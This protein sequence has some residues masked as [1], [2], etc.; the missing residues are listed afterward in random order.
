M[1]LITPLG[2]AVHSGTYNGNALSVAAGTACLKK[3]LTSSAYAKIM[4]LGDEL[5]KGVEDAIVDSETRAA[6]GHCT[7]MGNIFFGLDEA[8][9]NCREAFKCDPTTW[10]KY[11]INMLNRGVVPAGAGWF[12]EWMVSAMHEADDIKKTI[13]ATYETL[14]SIKK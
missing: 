12:E 7:M 14:K 11:W 4:K 3:V 5:H 2:G 13:Q 6:V 1:E 10:Y 8:P 9:K